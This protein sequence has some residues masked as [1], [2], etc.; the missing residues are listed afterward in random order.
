M[1]EPGGDGLLE[2]VVGE[3]GPGLVDQDFFVFYWSYF[4]IGPIFVLVIFLLVRLTKMEELACVRTHSP[5]PDSQ[6]WNRKN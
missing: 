6:R 3:A 5:L 4:F 2:E 1:V